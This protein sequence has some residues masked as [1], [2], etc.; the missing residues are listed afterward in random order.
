MVIVKSGP[1]Q[2]PEHNVDLSLRLAAKIP[3]SHKV[4]IVICPYH[5]NVW[6]LHY[7]LYFISTEMPQLYDFEEEIESINT[8]LCW[9]RLLQTGL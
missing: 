1:T 5:S 8:T 3:W 2:N 9:L 7:K 6:E 4:L